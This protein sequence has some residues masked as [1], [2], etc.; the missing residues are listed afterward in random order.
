MRSR[1]ALP[2]LLCAALGFA[3]PASAQET[4]DDNAI[5]PAA[6]GDPAASAAPQGPA[7]EPPPPIYDDRLLRL[8]EILGALHFL[9]GLCGAGDAEEWR[10]DMEAMVAA[11]APGPNRRAR[12]VARFNYGFGTYESVY[13]ACTPAARR[14][15]EIYL[16]EGER[17]AN[18]VKSR[19][20][21]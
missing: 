13:R 15:I 6:P 5:A 19:Y 17:I 3:A 8:S 1:I 18:D 12:L 7:S 16:L 21:Q 4:P 11:E 20:G 2:L 10:V 14:A 9:R